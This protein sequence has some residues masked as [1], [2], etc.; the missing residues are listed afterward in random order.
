M[1]QSGLNYDEV[2][3]TMRAEMMKQAVIQQEVDRVIYLGF[4][5]KEVQDYFNSHPDKFRKPETIKLSEIW[6]STT[7]KDE[8]AVRTRILE[9]IM[10]ARAGADFGALRPPIQ[11]VR[12]TASALR[13]RIRATS[14]S[15]MFP[16][17]VKTWQQR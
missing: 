9:L 4:T 7:G 11:S 8:A 10:Q 16:A 15:L 2:R 6:L 3:R 13:R 14:A 17:S 12:R 5:P 1:K